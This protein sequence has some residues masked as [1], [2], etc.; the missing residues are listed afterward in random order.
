MATQQAIVGIKVVLAV[1]ILKV[2]KV[3]RVTK[4]V[5]RAKK[6]QKAAKMVEVRMLH[7]LRL[8]ARHHL[9]SFRVNAVSAV[10]GAISVLTAGSSK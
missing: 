3:E 6:D 9:P 7:L 2:A 5:E 1:R 4:V 8:L 10:D